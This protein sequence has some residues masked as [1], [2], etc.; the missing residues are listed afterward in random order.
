MKRTRIN[1]DVCNLYNCKEFKK[2]LEV[3][4]DLNWCTFYQC[5]FVK[6]KDKTILKKMNLIDNILY[7]PSALNT[8][9]VP[10]DC[11]YKKIHARSR[12]LQQLE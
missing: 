12:K 6:D 10:K 7:D 1:T 9:I 2:I 4:K 5:T 8:I 3:D 11:P